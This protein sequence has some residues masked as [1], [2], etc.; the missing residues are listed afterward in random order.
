MRVSL[1]EHIKVNS[2]PLLE[3]NYLTVHSFSLTSGL[4]LVLNSFKIMSKGLG[5][6][7]H[8]TQGALSK[9]LKLDMAKNMKLH[10]ANHS[11]G[12]ETK[13]AHGET[14]TKA[15]KLNTA[16]SMKLH[17]QSTQGTVSKTL[18][19]LHRQSTH[20]IMSKMLEE[21]YRQSTHGIMSK[22]C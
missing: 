18:E 6:D 3:T 22:A 17:R 13:I 4:F 10:T 14:A 16:K 20:G 19:G 11:Q 1:T 8:S 9:A 15:L 5:L 2:H 21:F 7:G 12:K